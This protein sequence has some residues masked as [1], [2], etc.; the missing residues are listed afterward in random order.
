[1]LH[2]P[3]S[4]LEEGAGKSA[5][6]QGLCFLAAAVGFEVLWAVM[7]RLGQGFGVHWTT[8]VLAMAY[9][10]SLVCL[11]LACRHVAMS[12]AYAVWTG[13]GASLVALIGVL[14]FGD[15]L[16]A[17]RA[18]GLLLVISGVVVLIGLER[19]AS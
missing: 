10:L 1:M 11:H 6:A 14:A 12:V 5:T 19:S 16:G 3:M 4:W 15:R 2:D 7:L 9:A 8:A 17:A 13:S 18:I